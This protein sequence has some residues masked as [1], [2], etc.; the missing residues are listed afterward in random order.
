MVAWYFH[1]GK[2]DT[3]FGLLSFYFYREPKSVLSVGT[4]L[5]PP[6]FVSFFPRVVCFEKF[7]D[8][9]RIDFLLLKPRKCR[10]QLRNFPH[11]PKH[12]TGR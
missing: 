7:S 8:T 3:T 5:F 9:Q 6:F 1:H 2:A 11:T 12:N 4:A 10:R